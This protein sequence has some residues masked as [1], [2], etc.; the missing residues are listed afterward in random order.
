[1]LSFQYYNLQTLVLREKTVKL[2]YVWCHEIGTSEHGGTKATTDSF[3]IVGRAGWKAVDTTLSGPSWKRIFQLA[4]HVFG[5]L[6]IRKDGVFFV[7]LPVYGSGNIILVKLILWRFPTVS[8]LQDI[9]RLRGSDR[10]SAESL[11]AKSAFIVTTGLLAEHLKTDVK[12][13]PCARLEVWDYLMA[14]EFKPPSWNW[15]GS[16]LFAGNLNKKKVPW[17]YR[18]DSARPSLLLYGNAYIEPVRNI[19]NDRYKGPFTADNPV[20]SEYVGWGLVW[21]G[22]KTGSDEGAA[23]DY[24]IINQPHKASLYLA[25]GLPLIVWKESFIARFVQKHQCGVTV[26]SLNNIKDVLATLTEAECERLRKNAQNLGQKA[27]E[28]LFLLQAL[29]QLG[30]TSERT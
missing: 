20:I 29:E 5:L 25:C 22:A 8:L 4:R 15:K 17:L 30:F 3:L 2:R 14:R 21:D 9:E 6:L 26:S 18:T 24:E 27:R 10:G 7:Q 16:I 13:I 19:F 1:M 28:G 23:F 12:N 11:T